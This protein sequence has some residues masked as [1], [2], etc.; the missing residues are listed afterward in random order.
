MPK[1]IEEAKQLGTVKL[2]DGR[3]V[4][5]L[6]CRSETTITNTETGYE[7]SSEEE[8]QKDIDNS[9]TETK[10]DHIRRDVKIFAP[11]LQDLIAPSKKN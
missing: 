1:I 4:P 6:S 9:G 5:R 8:V 7:Y 2:D 3:E 10:E 11:K